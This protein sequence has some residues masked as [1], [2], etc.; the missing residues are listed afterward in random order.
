VLI[1]GWRGL[2]GADRPSGGSLM[3][4]TGLKIAALITGS[5]KTA[6]LYNKWVEKLRYREFRNSET[7]IMGQARGNWDD[8][9]HLLG[10]LY[11]LNL[12]EEDEELLAFYRKCVRDSWEVHKDD[13]QAWYNFVYQTVLGD[14]YGDPEGSIWNLQTHPTCRLLQPQM[15][16]IRTDIDFYTKNGR[17][18]ALDPLPVYERRSD[19]EYEWK[20]GPYAL[21]GWLSRIVT[22][23][24]VSPH[25]PHVQLAV[26]KSG[27]AYWSNTK[28]EIWHS[29]DDLSGV[30]DVVLSPDY[31]WLAFAAT[32]EGVYRT[33]DGGQTW[34]RTSE[35]PVR[36]LHFGIE[37][38]HILYAVGPDGVYKSSDF[39]ERA[40][41]TQWRLISGITPP[42]SVKTFAVD[43]RGGQARLYM[44]TDQ[45]V[46]TK[47]EDDL[48]WT[49]PPRPV[50]EYGFSDLAPVQGQPLWI[51][52]GMTTA[53]RLFRAVKISSRWYTGVYISVSEDD[54]KTWSPIVRE[55]DLRRRL[56]IQDLRV[57]RSDPDIW[58]GFVES[59]V[60]VTHDAGQTWTVSSKGLDIPRVH[61]IWVPRHSADIY[62]GTRAGAY[63]SHDR[64][65]TW[66]STSLILQEGGALR[67]EIGGIGYLTAYWMAR[68]HGF[69]SEEE[70]D[71]RWWEE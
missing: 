2:G 40:M 22:I 36:Q 50:R 37:N 57:D 13:K 19:N 25:D 55:R 15:N 61:A 27:S 28:G 20:V 48:D 38:T 5:E 17:R 29:V 46:Y 67:S 6:E 34:R 71:R 54:G 3:A 49:T 53:R 41:G 42:D 62:A 69:I 33:S 18:E 43:P 59:G 39:G 70:A 47:S 12:I 66:Q 11:L 21:D 35:T 24:E 8:T 60:V 26:D 7:S 16:S 58:Y 45:G 14:E 9:D 44:F 1:G 56:A 64:G 32:D 65:D 52:V 68:Y 51:R 23:V 63:V 30:R 4:T 31:P 10:D